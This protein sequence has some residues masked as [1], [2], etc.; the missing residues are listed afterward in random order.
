[1]RASPAAA[2]PRPGTRPA[3]RVVAVTYYSGS[4]LPD[5]LS[6]LAGSTGRPV[7][8]VLADNSPPAGAPAEPT[9]RARPVRVLHTGG[10]LGYGAAANLGAAGADA[11]LLLI[12]NPDVTFHPGA[13]DRLLEAARRWPAA[14][15]FG[16]AIRTPGGALYPSARDFPSL[17]RGVGHALLGWIWP[18]NPWTRAYRHEAGGP[19]EEPT[20]WLSGSCLLVR[21]SA[22]EA[23]GGFDPRYFMYCEDMD[24]CLRFAERGWPSVYVPAA[25][26][27]HTG[28]HS[29]RRRPTRMLAEHHL[30]LY[31]YLSRQYRGLR[32]AWLRP[33]LAVGLTARFLA[34]LAVRG[35][36]EGARPTRP[37]SV[38]EE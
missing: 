18:A 1:V 6:S 26:V 2:S 5:F 24:L 28:G 14:A 8:V 38:L 31:R 7:E 12:A 30:S 15:A 16:P 17:R 11:E 22:F 33:L 13:V 29:T 9:F 32:W 3:L 4:A 37:A 36:R 23:V 21:R 19:R 35:I 25:V 27:T 10:N 34:G 20:G